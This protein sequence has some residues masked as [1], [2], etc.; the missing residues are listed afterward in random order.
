MDDETRKKLNP[1]RAIAVKTIPEASFSKS[2]KL[3]QYI[4]SEAEICLSIRNEHC[5]RIIEPIRTKNYLYMIMDYYNGGD[6]SRLLHAK[7]GSLN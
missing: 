4:E 7:K 6:L 5:C 1:N 3:F 2:K